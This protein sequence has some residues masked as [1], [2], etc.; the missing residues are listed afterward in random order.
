[1][2]KFTT[3]TKSLVLSIVIIFTSNSISSVY[4]QNVEF[5]NG[6]SI[7]AIKTNY[8]KCLNSENH[9]VRMCTVEY[10]GRFNL[11][12]F[13]DKLIEMLK[14]T[15]NTKDKKIIAFSLFQLGSLQSINI[16]RDSFL[17]S[18][19]KNYKE[20]CCVLLD[21]CGEYNQLRLDYFDSLVVSK[22]ETE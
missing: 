15:Q 16:L 4:A 21:K 14:N 5:L 12:N 18:N 2:K 20:F 3:I 22:V 10:V 7:E 8:E 11:T 9:G 6:N 1:M 13:E 19:D 17:S